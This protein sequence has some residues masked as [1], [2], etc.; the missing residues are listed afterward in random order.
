[1]YNYSLYESLLIKNT[2]IKND[3]NKMNTLI[4]VGVYIT[5]NNKNY[6]CNVWEDNNF[7]FN[8]ICVFI[9]NY[10]NSKYWPTYLVFAC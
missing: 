8:A 6:E 2:S 9:I 4:Y 1:M 3:S 5:Y 7:Q 10:R